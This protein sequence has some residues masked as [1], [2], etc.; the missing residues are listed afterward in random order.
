MK[1]RVDVEQI[2][3]HAIFV[4]EKYLAR[5]GSN[6][7]REKRERKFSLEFYGIFFFF[8]F[9]FFFKNEGLEGPN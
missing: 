8:V 6:L 4:C 1:V 5:V 3:Y 2:D 9:F 7:K